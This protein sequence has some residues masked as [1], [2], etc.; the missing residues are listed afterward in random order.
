MLGCVAVPR[1]KRLMMNL[2]EPEDV[3]EI[4]DALSR[5]RWTELTSLEELWLPWCNVEQETLVSILPT[6]QALYSTGRSFRLQCR[7]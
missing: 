7:A 2:E 5:T 6:S 4:A 3:T 1:L